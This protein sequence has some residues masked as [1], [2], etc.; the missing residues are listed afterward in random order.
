MNY[1]NCFVLY[2]DIPPYRK[3]KSH[4]LYRYIYKLFHSSRRFLIRKMVTNWLFPTYYRN[5]KNEP[6]SVSNNTIVSLTSFP[7]R[8]P[9]LWLVIESLKHQNI[10]PE[11]IILYLSSD[12]IKDKNDIPHSLLKEEDDLFEIRLRKG[13]LRAH[14]KYH[15]AMKEFP[16]KNIVTVDDDILYPPTMLQALLD[17]HNKYPTDVI[18][19]CTK[20]ILF[21]KNKKILPYNNWKKFFNFDDYKNGYCEKDN[22]IPMGVCGVLYPPSVLYKDVLNFD[23]AKEKSYLADDLWLYTQTVL[24]GNKVIKTNFNTYSC[25]P[26]EIQNNVT[27]ASSNVENNQNDVQF[28]QLRD[29][30]VGLLNTDIVK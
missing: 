10:K 2:G 5:H 23:L 3:G 16:D 1:Q 13:K 17:G 18:T 20:Q 7:K 8:L 19:N 14:G 29:Y 15:F 25:I 22:L 27:L 26:I 28:K 11:K 6:K 30:Y 24:A 21:D 9:T 4:K 12:E